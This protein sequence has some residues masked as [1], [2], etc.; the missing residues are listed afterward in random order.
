MLSV[1]RFQR[2]A[3]NCGGK[4]YE[5]KGGL[6]GSDHKMSRRLRCWPKLT[7]RKQDYSRCVRD[8]RD[9]DS[10]EFY[11]FLG[12]F[13]IIKNIFICTIILFM[14]GL[15]LLRLVEYN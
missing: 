2:G 13:F 5:I 7:E 15:Q 3:E 4:N 10:Y 11:A 14:Q 8:T 12:L 1:E 6:I 9:E